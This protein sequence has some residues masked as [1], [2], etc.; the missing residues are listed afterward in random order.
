MNVVQKSAIIAIFGRCSND[1]A[2]LCGSGSD[3]DCGLGAVGTVVA[4]AV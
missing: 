1:V 2:V 3:S 4:L